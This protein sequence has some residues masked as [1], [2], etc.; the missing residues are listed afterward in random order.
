MLNVA[1]VDVILTERLEE[2]WHSPEDDEADG[3]SNQIYLLLYNGQHILFNG[4]HH[5]PLP[6]TSPSLL[7]T[8]ASESSK[9]F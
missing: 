5:P 7:I 8:R 9:A 4:L 2:D 3:S 6:H 1:K